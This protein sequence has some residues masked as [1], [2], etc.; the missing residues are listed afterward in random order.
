MSKKNLLFC[1]NEVKSC[2]LFFCIIF[3]LVLIPQV[4]GAIYIDDEYYFWIEYPD[5]WHIEQKKILIDPI[6]EINSGAIIFPSFRDGVYWW[7]HFASVTLHKDSAVAMNYDGE[8]F[9][10]IVANELKKGCEIASFD[11]QGYQCVNHETLKKEIIDVNG[12]TA[13]QITDSWTE[14]YPDGT[15]ATKVSIVTDFVV[16]NNLWQI[17]SIMVENSYEQGIKTTENIIKSFKF[18]DEEEVQ[19]HLQRK[20][21]PEW[22]R[23]N[24]HSWSEDMISDDE[25]VQGIQYLINKQIMII[26]ETQQ[27]TGT[28]S[29]EIPEWIRNNAEWWSSGQIDDNSF[30]QGIQWLIKEGI[31]KLS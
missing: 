24:A 4:E 27:G 22:V 20:I 2:S 8:E 5:N 29:N 1:M 25:F 26:P 31:I 13:Y 17:D 23:N 15:N 12:M 9:L 11:F 21:I 7:D 3:S 18:I 28:G 10:N 14:Q 16:G 6:P 19:K 30:V